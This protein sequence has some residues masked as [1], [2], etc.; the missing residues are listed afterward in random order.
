MPYQLLKI[1]H[2]VTIVKIMGY[3]LKIRYK[4]LEIDEADKGP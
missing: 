2:T 4:N 1:H 3:F